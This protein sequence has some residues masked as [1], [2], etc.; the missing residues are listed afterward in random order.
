MKKFILALDR[1]VTGVAFFL[2]CVLLAVVSL[3][4]IWQVGTRFLFS[5]PSTWTEE[6]LRRLLIWMVMLGAAVAFRQGALISVDLMLRTARG[7]WRTF[8]NWVITVTSLTLLGVLIWY[9]FDLVW[10]IVFRPG[11]AW[12]FSRWAGL[13]RRS[14]WARSFASSACWPTRSIRWINSS[15]TPCSESG[16][17]QPVGSHTCAP[18]A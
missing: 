15:T 16:A 8:V 1:R 10:R 17:G 5:Q 18:R 9:G 7:K 4:G 6:L 3:L 14:P 11:Q 12:I 2:A 13:T